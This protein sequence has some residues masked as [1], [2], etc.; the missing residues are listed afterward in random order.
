MANEFGTIPPEL[1]APLQDAQQRKAL[2]AALM[3]QA[4]APIDPMRSSGRYIVPVSPLEGLAKLGQSYFAAKA[5]KD[6]DK[7]Y[8]DALVAALRGRREQEEADAE[9]V[10][11]PEQ[12][13]ALQGSPLEAGAV[14]TGVPGKR[15]TKYDRAPKAGG[16]DMQEYK[17]WES[18][19]GQGGIAGFLK[20]K[21]GLKQE[22]K[23]KAPPGYRYTA[24]GDLEIIPGGPADEKHKLRA[25][26][27]NDVDALVTTLNGYYDELHEGGGITDP[28]AGALSNIGAGIASSGPG[29]AAGRLFGTQNQ[30]TRNKIVQQRPL[31]LQAIKNATG[32]SAKQMDS[33]VEL[34]LYLSAA[35]DPQLDVAANKSALQK[36]AELYGSGKAAASAAPAPAPGF[37]ADKERRYQEWKAR[38]GAK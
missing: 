24:A 36:L 18:Q 16:D 21:A 5:G 15:V 19:G 23:T 1:L 27:G 8:N 29:Q 37:D 2:A 3:Q 14:A 32:M 33:N 17:L 13:Q 35:T 22:D 25:S 31:L 7:G 30:S 12:Y 4:Q 20:F 38:Q 10:L 6:A 34:K 28:D 26:G 9:R 11:T